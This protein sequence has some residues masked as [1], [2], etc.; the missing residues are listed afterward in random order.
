MATAWSIA[1]WPLLVVALLFAF[2]VVLYLGPDV[3][4]RRWQLLTPGAVVAADHARPAFDEVCV[5]ITSS[6]TSL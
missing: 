5:T 4:H 6:T 1:Q 3:E 2:S